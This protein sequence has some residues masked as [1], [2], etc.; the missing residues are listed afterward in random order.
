MKLVKALILA[1]VSVFNVC[2]FANQENTFD[3][4]ELRTIKSRSTGNFYYYIVGITN[5]ADGYNIYEFLFQ[6]PN[7]SSNKEMKADK[8]QAANKLQMLII[9][10]VCPKQE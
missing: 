1:L 7:R 9:N 5:K 2:V 8:S 3:S 4:C 6:T 10:E